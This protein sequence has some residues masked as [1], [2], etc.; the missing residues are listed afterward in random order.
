[1]TKQDIKSGDNGINILA[2]VVVGSRLHETDTPTSDWDYRGIHIHP[3]KD[4][5]S[6]FKTI[7]NTT[8]IEGDE[9]NTSYELSDFV[10]SA[11]KGNATILEVLFSDK[12]ITTTPAHQEMRDNWIKFFDSKAFLAAS[13]GYANNQYKKMLD[14]SDEGIKNQPRTAKFIISFL[15]VMWQAKT[16]FD[17]G[18]FVCS[19]KESEY[20]DFIMSIKGKTKIELEDQLPYAMGLMNEADRKLTE[21]FSRSDFADRTPD[22]DWIEDFVYRTYMENNNE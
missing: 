5:L 6:P 11:A 8:W 7:K 10:K 1:M 21:S 22:I 3:I 4:K 16:M 19:L 20:Y 14:Y 12:I 18:E 2:K 17:T 15:R 9:D 13:R